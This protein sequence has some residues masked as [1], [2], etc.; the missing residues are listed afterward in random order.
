MCLAQGH[1]TEM[2]VRL[3]PAA[4]G[5]RVKHSTSEP[6]CSLISDAVK[7]LVGDENARRGTIKMFEVLQ[8]VRLNKH[9]FYVSIR[10]WVSP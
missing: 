2:P 8:D 6:P 1:N 3:E 10:V 5:S 4:P 7:T 9:L